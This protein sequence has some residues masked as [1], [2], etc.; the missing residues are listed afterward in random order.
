M[1]NAHLAFSQNKQK[2]PGFWMTGK[3]ILILI[4]RRHS[5]TISTVIRVSSSVCIVF[6]QYASTPTYGQVPLLLIEKGECETPHTSPLGCNIYMSETCQ[7]R[8]ICRRE[9]GKVRA[10]TLHPLYIKNCRSSAPFLL[11]SLKLGGGIL[12]INSHN[13]APFPRP[14]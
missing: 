9:R 4:P 5:R 3:F 2:V 8:P 12:I 6:V 1:G 10:T 13:P 7:A 14:E 11:Y